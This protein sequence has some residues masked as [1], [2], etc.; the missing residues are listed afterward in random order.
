[1]PT[2]I[3]SASQQPDPRAVRL[4]EHAVFAAK[5]RS[6]GA[7][8]IIERRPARGDPRLQPAPHAGDSRLLVG[9]VLQAL[10]SIFVAD[11]RSSNAGERFDAVFFDTFL[12][13]NKGNSYTCLLPGLALEKRPRKIELPRLTGGP[14]NPTADLLRHLACV[15]L[16]Q[17]LLQPGGE[18]FV[19]RPVLPE[20][21]CGGRMLDLTQDGG[22]ALAAARRGQR[23]VAVAASPVSAAHLRR[24]LLAQADGPFVCE[25]V[26]DDAGATGRARSGGGARRPALW[27]AQSASHGTLK[28]RLTPQI[29]VREHPP[30]LRIDLVGLDWKCPADSSG[31][32]ATALARLQ[33]YAR[34]APLLLLDDWS[35]DADFDGVVFQPGW[36]A[37]RGPDR[38][39]PLVAEMTAPAS[40]AA[41]AIVVRA[42]D[43]LGRSF[44][45]RLSSAA[46]ASPARRR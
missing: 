28:L 29:D 23:W 45:A 7:L 22:Y 20:S 12:P 2:S 38:C 34:E 27:R 8:A 44:E 46:A 21:F 18:V 32:S 19:G 16:A 33:H 14:R 1:M 43:L 31:L 41:P 36:T 13:G 9:D 15:E 5:K 37:A 17:R 4:A 24:G 30:M 6:A 35:I 40:A 10:A 39:V 26:C 42:H 3:A 11:E 25:R